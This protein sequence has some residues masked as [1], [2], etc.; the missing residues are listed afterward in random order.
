MPLIKQEDLNGLNTTDYTLQNIKEH[1][2]RMVGR[3]SYLFTK[4]LKEMMG[5]E[6]G[7][8]WYLRIEGYQDLNTIFN[9]DDVINWERIRK[10][11][12]KADTILQSMKIPFTLIE[13]YALIEKQTDRSYK[14]IKIYTVEDKDIY[15]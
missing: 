15:T 12:N 8:Y 3:Y 2:K 1:R 11:E 13:H 10:L 14:I 7:L 5:F 9:D 4:P 6:Q